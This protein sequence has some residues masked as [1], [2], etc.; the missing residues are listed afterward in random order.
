MLLHAVLVL[1]LTASSAEAINTPPAL[2][3]GGGEYGVGTT[4]IRTAPLFL[5]RDRLFT[6]AELEDGEEELFM[7][8]NGCD[9]TIIDPALVDED[10]FTEKQDGYINSNGLRK[11]RTTMGI[12]KRIQFGQLELTEVL[13]RL[14]PLM[15][16]ISKQVRKPVRGILGMRQMLPYLTRIDFSNKKIEFLPHDE[17]IRASLLGR[18]ST[19]VVPLGKAHQM[20]NGRHIYTVRIEINGVEVDAIIDLGFAG[21][22]MTNIPPSKLGITRGMSRVRFPVVFGGY[23]GSGCKAQAELVSIGGLRVEGVEMVHFESDG[24]PPTT[25]LGVKFLRQ[26]DLTFDFRNR[27]VILHPNEL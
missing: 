3:D 23:K 20:E 4:I 7:I 24:A 15:R 12:L 5:I 2:E 6:L 26:F 21:T 19:I 13:V 18:P 27:E 11:Q 14:S 16:E 8:D 22:I 25:I 10:N 1:S 9:Y 17:A